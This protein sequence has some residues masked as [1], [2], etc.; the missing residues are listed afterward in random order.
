MKYTRNQP[1]AVQHVPCD[2]VAE[3]HQFEKDGKAIDYVVLSCTINGKEIL[4]KPCVGHNP[5]A[6]NTFFERSN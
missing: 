1:K 5:T 6:L 2:F 3:L 4:F